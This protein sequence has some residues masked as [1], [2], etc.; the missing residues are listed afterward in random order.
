MFNWDRI[1]FPT[2][3]KDIDKFEKNNSTI[4]VNIFGYAP[5]NQDKDKV[6]P[7]RKRQY[8]NRE[9]QVDLLLFSANCDDRHKTQHYCVIK[10]MS[11]LL[12]SQI[13]KRGHVEIA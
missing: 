7:L 12:S 4:S 3:L 6:Y 13:S 5:E 11:K 8:T 10:K 1:T 9:H 2:L